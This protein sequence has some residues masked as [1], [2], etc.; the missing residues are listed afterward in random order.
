M[1]KLHKTYRIEAGIVE[2]VES[3]ARGAGIS[4][5]EAVER[6]LSAGL[7]AG[8]DSAGADQRATEAAQDAGRGEVPPTDLRAVCD[9]LRASNADLRAEVS[10]LWAQLATKDE[11]IHAAHD[12]A[13]QAH[14]LH[15]AEVTRT[16]PAGKGKRPS[17]LDRLMGRRAD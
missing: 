10:R 2:A 14:R 15:A 4:N 3:Y 11:Q 8:G 6:L 5:G 7:S 9:V 16:L 12:L 13:D 17:I 1:A